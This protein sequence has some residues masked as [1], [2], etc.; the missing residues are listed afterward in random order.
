VELAELPGDVVV[1]LGQRAQP[2]LYPLDAPGDR[3]L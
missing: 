3:L 2:L 1:L